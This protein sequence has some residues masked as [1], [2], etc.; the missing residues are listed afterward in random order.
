MPIISPSEALAEE[1]TRDLARYREAISREDPKA[2]L[3]DGS[4]DAPL[5]TMSEVLG[6]QVQITLT[7]QGDG[8]DPPERAPLPRRLAGR[9][10]TGLQRRD[11]HGGRERLTSAPTK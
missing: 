1:A 6:N 7:V 3:E 2:V 4:R 5:G 9:C 11:H 8:E 10:G